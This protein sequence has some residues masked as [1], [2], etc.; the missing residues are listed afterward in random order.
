MINVS[1]KTS[2]II[3]DAIPIIRLGIRRY[4]EQQGNISI[5]AEFD[6]LEE[7]VGQLSE[8]KPDVVI[9]DIPSNGLAEARV[10]ASSERSRVI[11]YSDYSKWDFVDSVIK[12]GCCGFVSKYSPLEELTTAIAAALDGRRWISPYVRRVL[13]DTT[14]SSPCKCVGISPREKEIVALVARGMSS[15]Q[16]ADQLCVGVKTVESHRYRVF[17][18]LG[19][20]NRAQLVDWAIK[21]ELI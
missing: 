11:V 3:V 18:K 21:H 16:I 5:Q 1:Q 12:C 20:C 13:N 4:L 17:R 14:D 6:V 19:L 9:V 7:A 8:L 10:L 15:K 2:V